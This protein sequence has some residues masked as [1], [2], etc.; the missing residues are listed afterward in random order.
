MFGTHNLQTFKQYSHQW[1]TAHVVLLNIRPQLHHR[2]WRKLRITL[3]Q[4]FSTFPAACWC[5]SSSNLYLET[6]YKLLSIVTFT[7]IQTWSKFCLLYQLAPCW[8]AVWRVIFK[9]WVVFGVRFWK[10]KSW[11]KSKP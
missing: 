4:T 11:Q 2:K 8:Q 9:I 6:R 10:T 7:L 5:S 1:I 3:F